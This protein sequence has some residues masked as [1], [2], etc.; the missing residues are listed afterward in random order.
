MQGLHLIP[1]AV[2]KPDIME[3]LS[4]TTEDT[5]SMAGQ[6]CP[7][8]LVNAGNSSMLLRPPQAS[9]VALDSTKY[10]DI[11]LIGK[12]LQGKS[13]LGNKLLNLGNTAKSKNFIDNPYAIEADK[14]RFIQADDLEVKEW[15]WSISVTAKCKLV[16]NEDTKVRVLDTPGFSHS[17]ALISNF[18][19]KKE[20]SVFEGNL[21]IV[22]FI[23]RAHI[24][25][26]L[27]V[28]R[29]VYFLPI[30]GPLD[31]ADGTM[32]EELKALHHYYGKEVF[33]CMVVAVTNRPTEKYQKLGFDD[34]DYDMTKK[35]FHCALKEITDDEDIACPPVIYIGLHEDADKVLSKIQNALVLRES[36]L[37]LIF[38][39][40]VCT[41]CSSRICRN[42]IERVCVVDADEN[43]MPYFNS[44]CHPLFIP[45]YNRV[46]KFFG[47]LGH[48]ATLGIGTK[49]EHHRTW[50][51]FTNIDEICIS[52]HRPPGSD[53]CLTVG[54]KI[55]IKRK[56]TI[57]VDHSGKW[58]PKH[59]I[60]C[61]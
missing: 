33:N 27:M 53:G 10:Y 35:V 30:R 44:K 37:P 61:L 26:Q 20:L 58:L 52:C 32:Q 6:S 59:S 39:E 49:V 38:T 51:G 56:E 15:S 60:Q 54:E 29:I 7:S 17:S 8:K 22:R 1:S 11:V 48:V 28:R 13:T 18:E 45:K 42:G 31:K 40:M 24:M 55:T 2:D 4:S 47:G 34:D 14:K 25:F 57:T 3:K 16:S 5:A 12:T 41:Y 43:W 46:Q 23:I 36:T 21:L 9:K 50:P 19:M